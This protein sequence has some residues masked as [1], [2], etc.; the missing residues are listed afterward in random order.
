[1]ITDQL[2][3]SV[4]GVECEMLDAVGTVPGVAPLFAS[5]RCGPGRARL[6]TSN[7]LVRFRAPGSSTFGPGVSIAADLASVELRDGEDPDA[8]LRV[9][10]YADYVADSP[11]E[12]VVDLVDKW[13]TDFGMADIEAAD[14]SA[15]TSD[16]TAITLTNLTTVHL[17]QIKAWIDPDCERLEI[18]DDAVVWVSPTTEAAAL[19]L[20]DLA[21]GGTDV[22]NIKRT[23]PASTGYDADVLNQIEISF[24]GI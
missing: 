20:P 15:G 6:R 16:Q 1:M 12:A 7:G 19:E 23:I 8:W 22:L 9:Q 17:S 5:G 4:T 11:R 3:L 24:H 13:N 21:P 18:S 14:A 10:V 2:K